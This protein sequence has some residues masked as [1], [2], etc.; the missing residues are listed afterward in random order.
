M[1]DV[2]KDFGAGLFWEGSGSGNLQ[3]RAGSGSGSW[4][5]ENKSLDFFKTDYKLSK[6][7]FNTCT[8]TF[9]SFFM[10]TL[11]NTLNDK[12]HVIFVNC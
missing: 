10:F 1:C 6:I 4:L 9:M 11:E 3:P 5:K 12:F 2:E 8:S 7:R